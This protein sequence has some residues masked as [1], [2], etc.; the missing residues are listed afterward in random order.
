MTRVQRDKKYTA[1]VRSD[2]KYT[3]CV[4]SDQKSKAVPDIRTGG[5]S[6]DSI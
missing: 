1:V 2:Q 6:R 3:A 4:L 5:V